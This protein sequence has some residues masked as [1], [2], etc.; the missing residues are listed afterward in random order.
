MRRRRNEPT[1]GTTPLRLSLRTA[2]AA[3]LA[4]AFL[5][6]RYVEPQ[7]VAVRRLELTL[8]RLAPEFDGYRVV[9]MSDVHMDRWMTPGR[10]TEIV[11]LV[12]EQK[13][14]LVAATGDFVT[15]SPLSSTVPLAPLLVEPLEGLRAPDGVVAVLGNHDH[16]AG[17]GR[18]RPHLRR[19]GIVE[20]ANEVR[21]VR[22]G[23][24]ALHVA[25]VDSLYMG[26]DRLGAVLD[27][28]PGEGAAVLLAHEPAFALS[29]AATGRFDL[30][31]S[32]HSHGGQVRFPILGA[33]IYPRH[34]RPYGDGLYETRGMYAYT[35]RGLGTVLS[36]LRAN[37][38][39]EV[40]VLTLRSPKG[41]QQR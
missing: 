4:G 19:A 37:C 20:L 12:N 1:G 13:P 36:R 34:S 17:A 35:S 30:Q 38:R 23:P 9:H 40:S 3:L 41:G 15:Y 2:G 14:D 29:S 31:L 32:G 8:P 27:G 21:T 22:R 7:W 5:Y 10:L 33:P 16:R 6:A 24:S 11:G 26:R 25:G 39:P 28:L 18:V